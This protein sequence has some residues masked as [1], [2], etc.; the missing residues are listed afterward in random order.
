MCDRLS[1]DRIAL[2]VKMDESTLVE[3][4]KKALRDNFN[5]INTVCFE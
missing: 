4:K 3:C 5:I 2:A 1:D